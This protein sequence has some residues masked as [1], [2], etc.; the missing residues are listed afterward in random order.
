MKLEE[1]RKKA[2]P[3]YEPGMTQGVVNEKITKALIMHKCKHFDRLL[4]IIKEYPPQGLAPNVRE[5]IIQAAEEVE[6]I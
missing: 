4:E 3:G 1:A 6:G 2:M 5:A